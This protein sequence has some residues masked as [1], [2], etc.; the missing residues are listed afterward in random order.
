[1]IA[2]YLH[3]KTL[4]HSENSVGGVLQ[5]GHES[6]EPMPG[7]IGGSPQLRFALWQ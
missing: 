2:I 7:F 6:A 1:V 3:S 4:Q 5:I